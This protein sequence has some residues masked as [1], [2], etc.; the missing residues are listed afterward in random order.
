MIKTITSERY[1]LHWIIAHALL[2]VISAFTPWVLVAWF[3]GALL[4]SFSGV[5][6]ARKIRSVLNPLMVYLSSFELL[7]RMAGTSPFIPY[8]LGKYLLFGFLLIGI[9]SGQQQ[10]RAGLVMLLLLVPGMILGFVESGI[11]TLVFNAL[12]PVNMAL[13]IVYFKGQT[14]STVRF[15]SYMRLLLLPLVAVLF[16]TLIKSPSLDEIEFSL[17]ANFQTTGG[18]GSNQVST[19]FG[20]AVFLL[21]LFVWY[22]W[23]FSPYRW[24]DIALLLLFTFRGLLS[25]SRGGMIGG[26][27]AILVVMLVQ[28]REANR[29]KSTVRSFKKLLLYVPLIAGALILTFLVA[30]NITGGLLRLRY[31]G[32]TAG[33]LSGSK[34][35]SLGTITSSRNEIFQDDLEV[36][37]GHP[38]FGVGVGQ[39]MKNR[40]RTSGQLPHVE[41]SRLLS[42]H[43]I[44]GLVYFVI[45][46]VQGLYIFSQRKKYFYG[47]I[48]LAFFVLAIY[49][50]FH[51]ATRTYFTPLFIG[52]SFLIVKP[53]YLLMKL[54]NEK[55]LIYRSRIPR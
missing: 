34:E 39:S 53:N 54:F 35:K 7:S 27:L 38:L 18:F 8:E 5:F 50:T 45:L 1:S 43:G 28:S 25:F 19:I 40:L 11:K 29:L 23:K 12:G 48:F 49:T 15:V 33:T 10:G 41:M 36:F 9:F 51:A 4:G 14:I 2:G 31:A 13:A 17:N 47:N 55:N 16:Y 20:A 3:Y 6:N 44:L 21:F 42:E 24:L 46:L 22:R 26:A 30:D 37:A 32:E 52:L